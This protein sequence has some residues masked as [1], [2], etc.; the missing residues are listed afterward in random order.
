MRLS[1]AH[2][3]TFCPPPVGS[4]TTATRADMVRGL[5]FVAPTMISTGMGTS[6]PRLDDCESKELDPAVFGWLPSDF[7]ERSEVAEA[8]AA[9]V[10]SMATKRLGGGRAGGASKGPLRP[11]CLDKICRSWSLPTG[12]AI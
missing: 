4:I 11:Q 7:Q 12:F 8:A 1:R 5:V 10:K 9:P 2:K 3:T 6:A